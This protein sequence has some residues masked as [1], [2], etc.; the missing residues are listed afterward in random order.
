[1]DLTFDCH[2]LMLSEE[3]HQYNEQIEPKYGLTKSN[4]LMVIF[5]ISVDIIFSNEGNNRRKYGHVENYIVS[6]RGQCT[7]QYILKII[8]LQNIIMV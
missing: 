7:D 1:M 3:S 2:N 4:M 5:R 8:L 6:R